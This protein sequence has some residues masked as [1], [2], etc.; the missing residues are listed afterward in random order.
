MAQTPVHHPA[1]PRR[2]TSAFTL[3][4]LLVVVAIIAVLAVIALPVFN[5]M[6]DRTRTVQAVSDMRSIKTAVA[7]YYADY[8]KYPTTSGQDYYGAGG[9]NGVYSDTVFGDPNQTANYWSADLFNILRAQPDS[10]YGKG[11]ESNPNQ[12]VY[13]GGPFAKSAAQPRS[14]ITTQD[15]QNGNLTIHKGSLVDP[16]GNQYIVWFNVSKSGELTTALSWFYHDYPATPDPNATNQNRVTCGAAPLGVECASM[17]PNS[18]FGTKV[19]TVGNQI[20]KN[21]D[22]IVTWQRPTY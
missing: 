16:W 14:G 5:K 7:S 3:I 19:G 11:Y 17:G 12:I 18:V 6:Q 15:V 9:N 20:L 22:D 8:G 2:E 21:S 1:D 13:W 4:E 10:H